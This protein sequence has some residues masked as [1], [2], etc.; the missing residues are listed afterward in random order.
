VP[1]HCRELLCSTHGERLSGTIGQC[2][3]P[4]GFHKHSLDVL[5]NFR[6]CFTIQNDLLLKCIAEILPCERALAVWGFFTYYCISARYFR[7]TSG[8]CSISRSSPLLL[9][10]ELP[11]QICD[12]RCQVVMRVRSGQLLNCIHRVRD[13]VWIGVARVSARNRSQD[14]R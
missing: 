12:L 7:S 9:L 14:A 3:Q 5:P 8:H 6:A 1:A 4:Y 10:R 11:L 2:Q 13:D